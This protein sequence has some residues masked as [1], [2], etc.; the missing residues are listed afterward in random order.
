MGFTWSPL[1]EKFAKNVQHGEVLAQ[2]ALLILE[3]VANT[4]RLF[5]TLAYRQYR[6]IH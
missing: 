3:Y 5:L 1:V 6:S 2:I 4:D